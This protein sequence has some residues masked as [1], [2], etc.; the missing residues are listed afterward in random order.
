MTPDS[1]RTSRSAAAYTITF[2]TATPVEAFEHL[3]G[4]EQVEQLAG[5]QALRLTVSGGLD[6]VVKAAAQYPIITLTSHE[7]SLEDI[8]LRYYEGDGLAAREASHVVH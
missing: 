5:G 4:V 1:S 7:P 2:A 8:F 3:P 6:G